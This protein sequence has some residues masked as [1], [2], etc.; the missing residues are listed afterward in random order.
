MWVERGEGLNLG[1]KISPWSTN[2]VYVLMIM[3]EIFF[4]S[5]DTN[6]SALH[7]FRAF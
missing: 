1:G 4:L 2:Q 7:I 3:V 5:A 6:S